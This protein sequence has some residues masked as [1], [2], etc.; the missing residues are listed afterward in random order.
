[1]VKIINKTFDEYI[2]ARFPNFPDL[3]VGPDGEDVDVS[4]DYNKVRRIYH[5]TIDE[6]KTAFEKAI[7]SEGSVYHF[8]EPFKLR[9]G[10]LVIEN[11]AKIETFQHTVGL[12]A[13]EEWVLEMEKK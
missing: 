5:R 2:R 7:Q 4:F 8:D 3:S 11:D 10:F 13:L 1:M 6:Y 12:W 9:I